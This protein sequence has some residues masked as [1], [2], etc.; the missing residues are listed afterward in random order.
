VRVTPSGATT[1]TKPGTFAGSIMESRFRATWKLVQ[2][3]LT[4]KAG[5]SR[6]SAAAIAQASAGVT[7]SGTQLPAITMPMSRRSMPARAMA[8]SAARRPVSALLYS[9]ASLAMR[10]SALRVSRM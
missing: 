4:S 8:I 10:G 9:I 2:A 6:P 1:S 5:T 7:T 3:E